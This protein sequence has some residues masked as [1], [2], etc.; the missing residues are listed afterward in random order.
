VTSPPQPDR[1]LLVVQH[2]ADKPLGR[3]AQAFAALGVPLDVRPATEELPEPS[4]YAG[5]VVLPG[6]A[7]PVDDDPP[8]H[9]ARD[10]IE[11][12]LAADVPVLGLCLGGQLLVQAL[13][14]AV[15][16]CE[17]ELGFGEISATAAAASDPLLAGA[18]GRF[19]VFHAHAFAFRPPS[20]ATVL[21][22]NRVCVQA[23][24][25][26]EAWAFQCHPEVTRDWV[27]GVAS[28]IRGDDGPVAA[29]TAGFFRANG[30]DPDRLEEDAARADA[31]LE[32][33]AESI[34]AGF[35]AR[36]TAER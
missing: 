27:A 31:T 11:Q 17:P 23:C 13:G 29:A 32:R 18:P 4:A 12:A 30:I 1:P 22:E 24:R 5:L 21:L 9:R 28:G 16:R 14:G 10:A 20:G 7:D 2:D 26:G 36:C 8:V 15:Y 19:D 25:V 34:A 35:A 6:L 3:I 33:V